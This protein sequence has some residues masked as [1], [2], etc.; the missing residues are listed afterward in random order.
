MERVT[1][2]GFARVMASADE[3]GDYDLDL[4]MAE[5]YGL[6]SIDKVIFLNSVCDASGVAVSGFTDEDLADLRSLRDVIEALASH[7]ETAA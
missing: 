3:A 5:D 4:D 1:R 2:D 6:T 7:A